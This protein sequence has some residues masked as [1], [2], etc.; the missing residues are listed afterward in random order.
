LIDETL[1]WIRRVKLFN[2]LNIR[3]AFH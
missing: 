1:A 2:K 3:Q